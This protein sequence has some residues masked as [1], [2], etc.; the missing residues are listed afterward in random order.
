MYV[1]FDGNWSV[2]RSIQRKTTFWG[3]LKEI[4]LSIYLSPHGVV[5]D[6]FG[7]DIVEQRFEIHSRSYVHFMIYSFGK[8]YKVLYTP[9]YWLILLF[10]YGDVCDFEIIHE[11]WYL[12]KLTY[13]SLY[14]YIYIRCRPYVSIVTPIYQSIYQCIY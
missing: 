7:C 12:N 1:T 13:L 5:A 3:T 10:I 8:G 11:G 2:F 6:V 14:I 4:Y 9:S